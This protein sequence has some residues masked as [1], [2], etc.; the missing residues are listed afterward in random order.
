VLV[1]GGARRESL[2]HATGELLDE[3]SL[4]GAG[5]RDVHCGTYILQVSLSR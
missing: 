2:E 1:E 4:V 3:P 5:A